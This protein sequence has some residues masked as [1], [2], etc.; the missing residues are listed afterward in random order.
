MTLKINHLDI[1][2]FDL[3][4]TLSKPVNETIK[5]SVN[6]DNFTIK[7]VNGIANLTLNRLDINKHLVNG[8]VQSIYYVNASAK[9]NF[10]VTSIKTYLT[11]SDITI[12]LR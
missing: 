3:I 8:I 12:T 6:S 9:G 4:F 10:S 2:D 7:S 5:V 1:N 11:T